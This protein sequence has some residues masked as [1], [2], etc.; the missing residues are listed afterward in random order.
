[1][2]AATVEA[3]E[4]DLGSNTAQDAIVDYSDATAE[5]ICLLHRV[6]R[7]YDGTFTLE[8]GKDIPKLTTVLRVKAS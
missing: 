1:M 3:L 6:S 4:P 7:Q 8:P 2:V 5:Y